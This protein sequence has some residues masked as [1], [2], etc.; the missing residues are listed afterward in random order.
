MTISLTAIIVEATKDINFGLPVMLVLMITK[1][2]GDFFNEVSFGCFFASFRSKFTAKSEISSI[3]QAYQWGSFGDFR[4]QLATR[5]K[6][7]STFKG[8]LR[9]SQNVSNNHVVLHGSR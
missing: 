6:Y 7:S 2:V 4:A 1:W 3:V 8:F 9:M 5:V